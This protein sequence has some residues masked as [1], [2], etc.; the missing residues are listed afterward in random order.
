MH[1]GL[2]A[3]NVYLFAA[4]RGLA[5]VLRASVDGPALEKTLGLPATHKVVLA[6]TVGFPSVE[7]KPSP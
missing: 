6:Q 1:A 7:A 4:S 2:A 3:Q 5:T